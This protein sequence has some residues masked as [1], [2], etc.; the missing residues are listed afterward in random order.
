M[1]Q[2]ARMNEICE[3]TRDAGSVVV[4]AAVIVVVRGGRGELSQD[5]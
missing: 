5:Y 4:V 1:P 2:E 3:L